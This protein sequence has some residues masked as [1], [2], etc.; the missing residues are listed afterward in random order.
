MAIEILLTCDDGINSVGL[1]YL[2]EKA[3]KY[4]NITVVA[5]MY[6]QSAK[7]HAINVATD[8][9]VKKVDLFDGVEA[10]SVDSTPADCV[11]FAYYGLKRKFDYIFSGINKGF[12]TGEDIMYSGTVSCIFEAGSVKAKGIAFSSD[13][14]GFDGALENFDKVM[15][16]FNNNKL[17]DYNTLYNVNFPIKCE[18][19]KITRQGG[20]NFDTFFLETKNSFYVQKGT[21]TFEKDKDYLYLDTSCVMNNYISITPLTVDRTDIFAYEKLINKK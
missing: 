12:N 19:I 5:P 10:Y 15:D 16:Y 6:E 9:E 3:K 20:C 7:S 8:F 4:G 2:V 1:K 14:N 17:F 11:R 21:E 13:K 18:G